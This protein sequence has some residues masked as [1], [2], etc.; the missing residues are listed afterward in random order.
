LWDHFSDLEFYNGAGKS[1]L[2][3]ILS[4]IS[5]PAVGEVAESELLVT[6]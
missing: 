5:E 6:E 3:K 2:L 4:R 1:T